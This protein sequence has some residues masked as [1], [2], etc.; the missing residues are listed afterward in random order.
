MRVVGRRVTI[1]GTP[2]EIIGVLPRHFRFL[3]T[4]P[5]MLVPLGFDRAATR[6]QDFSYRGLARL[7][8]GVTRGPG[9]PRRGQDDRAR[10]AEVRDRRTA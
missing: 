10:S 9:Q 5:E 2:R 7:K 8:P 3:E 1:D 6:I 4:T